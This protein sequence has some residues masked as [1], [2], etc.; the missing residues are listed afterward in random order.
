MPIAI[1]EPASSS[2]RGGP[3]YPRQELE[4]RPCIEAALCLEV[5]SKL[6]WALIFAIISIIAGVFGFGGIA[7]GAAGIAKILF[8]ICVVIFVIFLVLGLMAGKA[9]L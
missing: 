5:G 9:V 1:A 3:L 8:F 4:P 6:K 2:G 7:A